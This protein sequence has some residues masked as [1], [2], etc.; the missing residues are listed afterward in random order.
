MCCDGFLNATSVGFRPLEWTLSK[1]PSRGADEWEPGADF[2]RAELVEF[3][4]VSVPC[5]PE[6]L[7]EATPQPTEPE[8]PEAEPVEAKSINNASHTSRE[9][10]RQQAFYLS[11]I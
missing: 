8:E 3:S 10:L 1:D 6:A 7:L 11:L 5:N 2:H 9:R 4:I